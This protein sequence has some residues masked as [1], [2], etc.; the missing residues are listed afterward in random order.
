MWKWYVFR[1]YVSEVALDA[2][3]ASSADLPLVKSPW[4]FTSVAVRATD[5]AASRGAALIY[6]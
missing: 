3:E 5:P 1:G 2:G 6:P 4:L